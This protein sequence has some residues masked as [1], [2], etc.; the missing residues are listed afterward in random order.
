MTYLRFVCCLRLG[1]K[2]A[3]CWL[4]NFK[5]GKLY[6]I[7][8][9]IIKQTAILGILNTSEHFQFPVTFYECKMDD[10]KKNRGPNYMPA[11]KELLTE[12]VYRYKDIVENKKTNATTT[13]EKNKAWIKIASEFNAQSPNYI[14]RSEES[15]KA[16]YK[17]Q[18]ELLK[19]KV[20][21]ERKNIYLTGGG[22]GSR[23]IEDKDELLLSIVNNKTVYGLNNTFDSD[24]LHLQPPVT[25]QNE[26]C[27]E[28]NT[29]YKYL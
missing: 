28:V 8:R 20:G 25:I 21:N 23:F 9:Q 11:E 27:L 7:H 15:L 3:A 12:I 2:S 4:L 29:T 24:S 16:Y 22:P 18:K 13:E 14:K 17:N 19:K 6:C 5:I 26:N 1:C 10:K